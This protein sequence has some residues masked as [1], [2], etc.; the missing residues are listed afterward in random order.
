MYSKHAQGRARKGS[1]QTKNSHG[2]LQLV[3]SYPIA[4]PSDDIQIKRF[5]FSTGQP[6]TPLGRQQAS[7][8]AAKIQRDIDY[9]EFDATLMQQL[10]NRW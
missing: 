10:K 9:G 3:F 6:D 4:T 5:Y 1:I 7:V 2:R 8:L